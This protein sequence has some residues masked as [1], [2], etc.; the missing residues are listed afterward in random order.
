MAA[1]PRDAEI[2]E[3]ARS[4]GVEEGMSMSANETG[5]G[6]RTRTRT[7]V[8]EGTLEGIEIAKPCG[9]AWESMAGDERTRFCGACRLHVYNVAGMTRDEAE[10]LVRRA[11][12]RV[13]VRLLRRADGTVITRDCPVALAAA[14][15]RLARA[16]GRAAAVFVL[17]AGSLGLGGC[18]SRVHVLEGSRARAWPVIGRL[19]EWIDPTPPPVPVSI[20]VTATMGDM[21]MPAPP[22]P[23][24]MGKPTA[25]R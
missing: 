5:D 8:P 23:P 12:G 16:I 14:R 9:V 22:P 11:D 24:L 19:L 7:S 3:P 1:M 17:A 13:C 20:P 6:S 21:V 4:C 15:R 10:A 25:P 18:R 2:A